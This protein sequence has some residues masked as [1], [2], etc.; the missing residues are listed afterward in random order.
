MGKEGAVRKWSTYPYDY[1]GT[2]ERNHIDGNK[3]GY[4]SYFRNESNK[5]YISRISVK[6]NKLVYSRFH[7]NLTILCQENAIVR[8]LK[9]ASPKK[10]QNRKWKNNPKVYTYALKAGEIH[11]IPSN[12]WLHE[13]Y[14]EW[15]LNTKIKQQ[16]DTSPRPNHTKPK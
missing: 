10:K 13:H 14:H 9:L 3:I 7:L 11:L 6:K 15:F 16:I 8:S 4:I 2:S 12:T 1:F 5:I